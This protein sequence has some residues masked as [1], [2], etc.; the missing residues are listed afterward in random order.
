MGIIVI[1]FAV[2][3]LVDKVQTEQILVVETR[4]EDPWK[5]IDMILYFLGSDQIFLRFH[6]LTILPNTFIPSAPK[7]L[8]K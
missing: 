4:K 2:I 1:I 3:G 6:W 8:L 7:S 5:N